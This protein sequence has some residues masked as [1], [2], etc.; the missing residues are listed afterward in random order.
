MEINERFRLIREKL[1]LTQAAFADKLGITKASLGAYEEGRALPNHKVLMALADLAGISIDEIIR[2]TETG[3][4]RQP[5]FS[6]K[7]IPLVPIKAAAGYQKGFPDAEYVKELPQFY[8]PTLGN[9]DYRAFEISGDSMPPLQSGT[10]VVGERVGRLTE[11][12]DGDTY[13]LVTKQDGIVYKRVFNYIKDNGKLFLVS[14]N[15][16]YK[17]YTIDPMEI[18][19]VWSARAYISVDFPK[20]GFNKKQLVSA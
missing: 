8:L 16:R 17:P 15:S 3:K 11:L 14:D 20:S 7:S 9:G 18:Y 6:G 12:K 5:N 4:I 19:E 13:V 1:D 10:I 2:G